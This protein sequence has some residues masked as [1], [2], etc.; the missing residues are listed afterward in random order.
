MSSYKTMKINDDIL[1][2]RKF[3]YEIKNRSMIN[4]QM[5]V[6]LITEE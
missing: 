5:S 3:K 4:F 6:F 2:Y 1:S